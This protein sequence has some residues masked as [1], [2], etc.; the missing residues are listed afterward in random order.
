MSNDETIGECVYQPSDDTYLLLDAVEQLF[1]LVGPDSINDLV[2]LGSG[3]GVVT[4]ELLERLG[5][6][7]A[8]AVDISPYAVIE[9]RRILGSSPRALVVE[10]DAGTCIRSAD[11]V[12]FNPPYLPP[13]EWDHLI[14]RK[15]DGWYLKALVD[16]ESMYRMCVEASRIARKAIVAVYSSIS[17]V[18]ISECLKSRGFSVDTVIKLKMFF[19]DLIALI[20]LRR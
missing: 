13:S 10:C 18:N 6:A 20:A 4:A 15:C 11:L 12:V 19:E 17:P 5:Q 2:E 16:P 1:K 7:R 14:S 8:V 9:T 3:S